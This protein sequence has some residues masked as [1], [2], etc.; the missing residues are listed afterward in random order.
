FFSSIRR[1]TR[2]SRD[3]SLDV[4]SS[5][6]VHEDVVRVWDLPAGFLQVGR[7]ADYVLMDAPWG[8]LADDARG[9]M[10]IGDIPGVA[11]VVTAGEVRGLR[12]R[13]TP[14]SARSAT[15]TPALTHLASDGH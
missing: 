11:A 7:D 12:S 1:D 5:D 9:A 13:N 4:C 14:A 10:A 15:P 3:W 2:F 8:S 6:L